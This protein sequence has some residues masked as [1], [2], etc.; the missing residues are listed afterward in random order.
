[1][2]VFSFRRNRRG[3]VLLDFVIAIGLILL[4]SFFLYSVGITLG[5]LLRGAAHFFGV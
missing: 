2:S 3:G 4:A 1:M 5:D